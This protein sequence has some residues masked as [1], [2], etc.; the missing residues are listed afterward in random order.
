MTDSATLEGRGARRGTGSSGSVLRQWLRLGV[1]QKIVL[2]LLSTL[3]LTLGAGGWMAL[4]SYQRDILEETNRH[5]VEVTHLIA[6]ALANKVVGHDYEAIQLFL[7]EAV[8]NEGI[9]YAKVLSARGNAMAEAGLPP[10]DQ[11]RVLYTEPIRVSDD[12]VGTLQLAL[13]TERILNRMEAAG[14]SFAWRGS[15]VILLIALVEFLA[16]SYVIIR[17]VSRIARALGAGPDERVAGE[18][19]VAADDEF[20]DMARQINRLGTRWSETNAELRARL[21]RDDRELRHANEQLR[22]QSDELMRINTELERLT[23]TDP[24]TGL[25]NRRHFETLME[26]EVAL[27]VRNRETASIILLDI[28]HFKKCNDRYGHVAG[29]AI[30]REIARVV[31]A[32][33]RTTDV[34][35]RYAGDEFFILCR[36]TSGAQAMHVAEEISHAITDRPMAIGDHRI[37]VTVSVGVATVPDAG[38]VTTAE[39]FFHNADT[40]LYRSKHQG[41]NKVTHHGLSQA[42]RAGG[43]ECEERLA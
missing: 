30:L 9:A 2:V 27:A 10:H 23:V 3:L 22:R 25:Y 11:R 28:D 33:M 17:P 41:R 43:Y 16:L 24:L 18:I 8:K 13:S 26:Q 14:S 29:D 6:R 31:T 34:V 4:H 21:A 12:T 36:R 7:D 40:A 32:R 19:P 20:G 42:E 5:G 15:L 39:K 1:R 35:C 38:D 37:P